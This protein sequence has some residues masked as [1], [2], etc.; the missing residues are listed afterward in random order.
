MQNRIE[1]E[2]G[3]QFGRWTIL[4]DAG[5]SSCWKRNVLCRC[6]C[7][8]TKIVQFN[9]LRNGKSLSCGCLRAEQ[10]K[11]RLTVHGH[12]H[13]G[14]LTTEYRIWRGIV[15][16]CT[17]PKA[18]GYKNYGG[19]GITVCERWL[20]FENF[21]ADMGMRP[22]GDTSIDRIDNEGNYTPENCRWTTRKQ[23]NN[24]RR[25]KNGYTFNGKHQCLS[26]WARE[27]GVS[28]DRL[29]T[30]IKAGWPVE[31][32]FVTPLIRFPHW[33]ERQKSVQQAIRLQLS[34]S[35]GGCH[36]DKA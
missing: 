2:I 31:N 6:E 5:T 35:A 21:L 8:K 13:R 25:V 32:V 33:R 19:R 28:V 22:P 30:R 11:Q 27:L 3:V 4:Q 15:S 16:R 14:H 9:N 12:C 17:T 29:K 10:L 7:G 23:Q 1:I 36:T 18:S 20:V 26:A 24:N 34:E